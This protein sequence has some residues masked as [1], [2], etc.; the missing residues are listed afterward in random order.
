MKKLDTF[1]KKMHKKK[2]TKKKC[3]KKK[4]TK[5]KY[6]KMTKKNYKKK[7]GVSSKKKVSSEKAIELKSIKEKSQVAKLFSKLNI[8]DSYMPTAE[9]VKLQKEIDEYDK[10]FRENINKTHKYNKELSKYHEELEKWHNSQ[11]YEELLEG[12]YDGTIS[13]EKELTL[14]NSEPVE[15]SKPEIKI[16]KKPT[17]EFISHVAKVCGKKFV[18]DI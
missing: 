11:N 6:L 17:K 12:I 15:P 16:V 7:G 14:R 5:K 4:C 8:D 18:Q 13:S 3:T 9:C 2:C 10:T 1:K